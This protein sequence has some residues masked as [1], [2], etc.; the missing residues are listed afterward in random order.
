MSENIVD[1]TLT[2]ISA[3]V[4]T[5]LASGD[6]A[7]QVTLGNYE[8]TTAEILNRIP[9]NAREPFL[10]TKNIGINQI[11]LILNVN[12]VPYKVGSKWRLKVHKNGTLSLVEEK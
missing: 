6:L 9:S 2:V 10:G 7:Y 11:T 4:T 8:K 3:T 12:E 1:K 5:E